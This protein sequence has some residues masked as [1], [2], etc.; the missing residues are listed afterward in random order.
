MLFDD[1]CGGGG[2]GDDEWNEEELE[3]VRVDCLAGEH[4][5]EVEK[6]TIESSSGLP[7]LGWYVVHGEAIYFGVENWSNRNARKW[8]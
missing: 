2:G 3:W 8:R 6:S 1:D 4:E 7:G 5:V